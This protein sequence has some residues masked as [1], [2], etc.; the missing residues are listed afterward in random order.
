MTA[1]WDWLEPRIAL[2]P[3]PLKHRMQHA[4]Q[5]VDGSAS[6]HRQLA[7][8]AAS[9]LK[10]ALQRPA[11][12]AAALDLLSADALLTHACA[13]AEQAGSEELARFTDELDTQFFEHLLEAPHD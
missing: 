10:A 5:D 6:I 11:H 8:G 13:A 3:D 4:L 2:A 12:R 9:C 7:E 1:A